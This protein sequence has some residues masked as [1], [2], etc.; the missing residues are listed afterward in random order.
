[1][2]YYDILGVSRSA[3]PTD[4]KQAYKKASMKHHPDRGGDAEKFK[5][6]SE[7]Y[8][9]LKD[10]QKRQQYDNPQPHVNTSNMGGMGGF[11]DLFAQFG[12]RQQQQ[13]QRNPDVTI[14]CSITLEECL[15]GKQVLVTYQL[16]NGQEETVDINIP[17]GA[18]HGNSVRYQ[19][20]GEQIVPG[21][22]GNLIV[23]IQVQRHNKFD[24]DGGNLI[25]RHK[26]SVLDLLLGC[27]E[28]I[29][30]LDGSQIKLTIPQGTK[31]GVTFNVTGHGMPDVSS[32]RRGN[33]YVNIDAYTPKIHD[34]VDLIKLKEIKDNL[35]K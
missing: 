30:T 34:P 13:H 18:Q 27:Q 3:S 22:R 29:T 5:E 11:E 2:N 23:Q 10:P 21:P 17:P 25:V 4:L 16:R 12:F 33:L 32:N 26:I 28:H 7:A 6:V 15:S 20:L 24:R 19:G 35:A 31:P 14:A 9:T 1:M 8:S